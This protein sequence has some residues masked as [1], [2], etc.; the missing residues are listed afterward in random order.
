MLAF[1]TFATFLL[2]APA[3]A[4][5]LAPSGP[6]ITP[7]GPAKLISPS[8]N[9][10]TNC[11]LANATIAL[12]TNQTVLT[13]TT[14][15]M[16]FAGLGVGTQNYTCNSTSLTYISSGAVAELFDVSCLVSQPSF[17]S[18]QDTAFTMWTASPAPETPAAL[19]TKLGTSPTV[20]GQHYFVANPSGAAGTSPKWDF[21]SNVDAGNTNAFV[22]GAKTGD[23]PAP[24]GASDVDWLQ[25]KNVEGDLATTV[26][27]T[28]TRGGQPPA[29]CTAGS[30]AIEVKYV[31]KYFLFK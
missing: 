7:G 23:L 9:C 27:R 5:P 16:K 19:I 1:A 25:L 29:S 21:T 6:P 13:A 26:Y 30:P 28:D 15:A 4:A 11:S 3:L 20:L 12:P 8:T 14:T 2:A 18:L 17:A 31:A 24:T 22:I 10:R